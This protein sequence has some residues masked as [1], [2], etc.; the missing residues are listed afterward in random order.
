MPIYEFYCPD[1]HK[2]YSFYARSLAYAG[3]TP[4]CPDGANLRMERMISNFA[5]TG[6]A[7]E[8]A[9]KPG[10]AEAGDPRMEAAMAEMEREFGGMDTE[11]PDPRMLARMMRKM[12]ALS[13]EKVPD[14]M[15]EMIRRMEAGEDPEKLEEELGDAIGDFDPAGGTAPGDST[16]GEKLKSRLQA[17][18]GRPQR[19]PTFYDMSDYVGSAESAKAARARARARSGGKPD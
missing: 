1:N 9:D 3:L 11:N 5:I 7:K 16:A 8:K 2:I 12:T 15:E 18:R 4:R 17:L 13:G 10:G 14:E 6:R 19:D